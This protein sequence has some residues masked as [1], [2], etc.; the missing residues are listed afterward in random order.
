M[1]LDAG[2]HSLRQPSK[3]AIQYVQENPDEVCPAGWQPGDKTMRPHFD[4]KREY[5]QDE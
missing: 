4:G 3:D 1:I 5:F 2:R